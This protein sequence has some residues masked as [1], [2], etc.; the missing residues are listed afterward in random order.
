MV[1]RKVSI[2]LFLTL[3]LRTT[4]TIIPTISPQNAEPI[5][6]NWIPEALHKR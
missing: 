5:P 1:K 3:N 4:N 2:V 6:K